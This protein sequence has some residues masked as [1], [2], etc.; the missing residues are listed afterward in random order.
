MMSLWQVDDAAT[1]ELMS[2]FYKRWMDGA[3]KFQAFQ[4]TQKEMKQKYEIPYFWGA[5][6]LIGN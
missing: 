6:I 4:E 1:Q 3:N 5:F 2:R